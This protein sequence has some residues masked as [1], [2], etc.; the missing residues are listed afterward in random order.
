L[1]S[2]ADHSPGEDR[3]DLAEA[4]IGALAEPRRYRKTRAAARQTILDRYDL[5]NRCLPALTEL[6]LGVQ[7]PRPLA[8]AS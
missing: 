3:C 7:A 4:V 8:K 5:T 1:L 2:P 6:L